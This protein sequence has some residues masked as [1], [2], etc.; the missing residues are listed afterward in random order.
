MPIAAAVIRE[1]WL[2]ALVTAI[3]VPAERRGAA[4]GDGP[5]HAPMLPGHPRMVGIQKAIA[6]L[7]HD[8][9]HLE[10]WPRHCL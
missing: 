1:G 5:E 6:V 8:V 3:A 4:L 9:G 2:R 7:A 10:G